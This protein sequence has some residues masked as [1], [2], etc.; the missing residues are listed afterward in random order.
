[1]NIDPAHSDPELLE[2]TLA[3]GC[4]AL[5]E[6][7]T[8]KGLNAALLSKHFSVVHSIEVQDDLM[9]F[10]HE[11]CDGLPNVHLYHGSSTDILP[12]LLMP[13]TVYFLDAHWLD[14]CPLLAEL[15]ILKSI[16]PPIIIHDFYVPETTLGY[17][18]YNEQ[19]FDLE[20]I[21]PHLWDGFQYFYS[22]TNVQN[23]GVI[24]IH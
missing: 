5:V 10:C 14:N 8:F 7:G 6:T 3:F 13:N 20:W 1:M 9:P 16:K 23:R 12:R 21:A 17:D 2:N 4:S 18:S 22:K 15:D 11:A 24:Y 19:R